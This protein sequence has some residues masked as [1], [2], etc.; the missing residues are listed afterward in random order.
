MKFTAKLA[1]NTILIINNIFMFVYQVL[2]MV[3]DMLYTL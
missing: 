3:L 1:A 2:F